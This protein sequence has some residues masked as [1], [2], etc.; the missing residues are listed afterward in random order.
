MHVPDGASGCMSGLGGIWYEFTTDPSLSTFDISGADFELFEGSCSSLT[1]ISDCGSPTTI[2][3]DAST[4]Y[5]ILVNGDFSIT[6]PSSP[7]ND[8]WW[9]CYFGI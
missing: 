3:A 5:Y 7:S 4:T 8:V 1:Q 9:R 2:G 6:T